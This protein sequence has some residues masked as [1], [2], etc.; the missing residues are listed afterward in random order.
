MPELEEVKMITGKKRGF[1]K[2]DFVFTGAFPGIIISDVQTQAPCCEVWGFDHEIGSA[3]AA[4]LVKLSW[5]EFKKMAEKNGFDGSADSEA[6]KTAIR[7]AIQAT[8]IG[9]N[10]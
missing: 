3:Y 6:A 8:E 5:P 7:L 10:V 9:V 2:G 1:K 4:D